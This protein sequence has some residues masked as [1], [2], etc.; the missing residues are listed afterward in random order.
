MRNK[1][2][3]ISALALALTFTFVGCGKKENMENSN[4]NKT[5][6]ESNMKDNKKNEDNISSNKSSMASN[7]NDQ[8]IDDLMQKQNDILQKHDKQWQVAFSKADKSK[9][10]GEPDVSY[11][12]YLLDLVE[13]SKD[14]LSKD[15]YDLLKKDVEEIGKIEK[16]INKKKGIEDQFNKDNKKET[17]STKELKLFPEFKSKDFDG[18]EVTKDIFK[19]KKLTLVNFW[20]NGCAPCV[21]EIP[22]L[23]KLNKEIEKMGGQ[24]IGINTEAQ[25]GKDDVI[26]EA[27][28]ILKKQGATY[29]NI[30]LDPD[31]E[32][33]KY[34][35]EIMS[36]PTSVLVDNEGNIVGDPIVGAIDKK[37][38]YDKVKTMME[39]I[40]KD[41]I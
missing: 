20:F 3:Q 22:H 18:N 24:V 39:K 15:D 10:A 21:G 27:K 32:L 6:I 4:S 41:E 17:G 29:K 8:S 26:E 28:K 14:E 19:D 12:M 36:Y 25:V 1:K 33:G 31:S 23:Q 35:Q 38:T 5:S 40:I 34:A 37:D 13:K 9:I 7:S 11:D 2:I 16:I 30:S